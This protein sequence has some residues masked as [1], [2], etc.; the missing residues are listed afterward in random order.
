[1]GTAA[2]ATGT[3]AIVVA[4][5]AAPGMAVGGTPQTPE[6][7]PEGMLEESKDEPEMEL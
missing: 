4:V 7:V 6:G 1:M 3:T 5:G 2:L